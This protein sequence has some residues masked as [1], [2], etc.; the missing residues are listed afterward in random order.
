MSCCSGNLGSCCSAAQ[1]GACRVEHAWYAPPGRRPDPTNTVLA[2]HGAGGGIDLSRFIGQCFL[3]RGYTVLAVARPGYGTTPLGP[4]PVCSASQQALAMAQL[5]DAL[6]IASFAAVVGSSAGC[7][8]GLAFAAE[9]PARLRALILEATWMDPCSAGTE[10]LVHLTRLPSCA[11]NAGISVAETVLPA[12]TLMAGLALGDSLHP[13]DAVRLDAVAR[14]PADMYS[15]LDTVIR[16]CPAGTVGVANDVAVAADMWSQGRYQTLA[17][18][19]SAPCT[20]VHA[21]DD[22]VAEYEL[23]LGLSLHFAR[24]RWISVAHSGH[25]VDLGPETRQWQREVLDHLDATLSS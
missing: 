19:V 2:L 1:K 11:V 21:P 20:M 16:R 6:G 8:S 9:H 15:L 7:A 4:G 24:V 22:S 12:R 17:D 14:D 10:A 3:E 23:A 13:R 18:A 5:A 25:F